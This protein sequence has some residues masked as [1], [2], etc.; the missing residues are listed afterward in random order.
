MRNNFVTDQIN[1][2]KLT[3]CVLEKI[4]HNLAN[5]ILKFV[6]GGT[7]GDHTAGQS[8]GTVNALCLRNGLTQ[9]HQIYRKLLA[10]TSAQNKDKFVSKF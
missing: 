1:K 7:G 4:R 3:G 5:T 2:T 9:I 8:F 10:H 6:N